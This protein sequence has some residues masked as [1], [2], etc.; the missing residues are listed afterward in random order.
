MKL[1]LDEHFAPAI[2]AQLRERGHDVV[3]VPEVQGL[4][5]ATDDVVLELAAAEGRAVVTENVADFA[6]LDATWRT[7]ERAHA[8]IVFTS[9]R[10]FP[11]GRGD[12]I[13]R[14]LIALD[15]L[16]ARHPEGTTAT[17]WL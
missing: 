6:A 10:R 15:E 4:R 16:I 8:G 5:G 1:L 9:N 12:T 14:L 2:A 17:H 13:G 7:G 3:A 11:R